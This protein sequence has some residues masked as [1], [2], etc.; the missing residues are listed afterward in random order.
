[1][2]QASTNMEEYVSTESSKTAAALLACEAVRQKTALRDSTGGPKGKDISD[3]LL[4]YYHHFLME[5]A[6]AESQPKV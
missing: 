2:N 4:T 1:M 3:E 5:L 6:K